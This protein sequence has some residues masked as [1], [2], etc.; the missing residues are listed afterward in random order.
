MMQLEQGSRRLL[1]IK[2][3]SKRFGL[4]ESWLYERSRFNALP[5][6]VRLGKYIRFRSEEIEAFI[7]NGGDLG[8]KKHEDVEPF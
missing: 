7:E 8:Q 6:L 2:E 1:T 5:G 3:V 4:P